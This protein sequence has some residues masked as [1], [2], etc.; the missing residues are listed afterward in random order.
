ML[1]AA[2]ADPTAHLISIQNLLQLLMTL[3]GDEYCLCGGDTA[4]ARQ[5][6]I[7]GHLGFLQLLGSSILQVNR[8]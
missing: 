8:I 7:Q 2:G 1:W 3:L 4:T 6:V 5:A